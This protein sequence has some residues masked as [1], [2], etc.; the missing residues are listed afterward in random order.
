[1]AVESAAAEIAD[2]V[3]GRKYLTRNGEY[4]RHGEPLASSDASRDEELQECGAYFAK[5]WEERASK[6]M[7]IDLLST[8]PC[9]GE[10]NT[11][12]MAELTI[13]GTVGVSD[14]SASFL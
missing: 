14:I 11:S 1:M 10:R 13:G 7:K 5:L 2:G 8:I 3:L 12:F 4:F 9:T 6:P